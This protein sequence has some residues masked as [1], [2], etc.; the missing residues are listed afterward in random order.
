MLIL[1]FRVLLFRGV[2]KKAGKGCLLSQSR[3]SQSKAEMRKLQSKETKAKLRPIRGGDGPKHLRIGP[4]TFA[5]G[6]WE[7]SHRFQAGCKLPGLPLVFL[8]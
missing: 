8:R 1:Y 7:E 5:R 2:L 6:S 3:L 4:N